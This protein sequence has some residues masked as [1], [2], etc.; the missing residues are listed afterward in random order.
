M[1]N[2]VKVQTFFMILIMNRLLRSLGILALLAGFA[3]F[4]V[5]GQDCDEEEW[6]CGD[7]ECIDAEWKCDGEKDCD[8]DTDES[9]GVCGEDCS[10]VEGGGFACAD[11]QQCIRDPAIHI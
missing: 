3:V 11:G 10:M 4:H 6:R 9:A 2:I 5:E 7:G 8:D 1:D